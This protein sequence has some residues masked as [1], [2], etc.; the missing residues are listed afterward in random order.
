MDITG[1]LVV[2]MLKT[3]TSKKALFDFHITSISLEN[4]FHRMH[5]PAYKLYYCTEFTNDMKLKITKL[6]IFSRLS[7]VDMHK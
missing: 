2:K 1:N 7:F 6:V 5:N 3:R 4:M